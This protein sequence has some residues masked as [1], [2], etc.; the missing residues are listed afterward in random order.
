MDR[1]NLE[2]NK[3]V[4]CRWAISDKRE[5]KSSSHQ[6]HEIET[7]VQM[8]CPLMDTDVGD[9]VQKIFIIKGDRFFFLR[10]AK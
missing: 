7:R 4:V 2:T 1:R 6:Q 3:A 9:V 5:T 10:H 8:I